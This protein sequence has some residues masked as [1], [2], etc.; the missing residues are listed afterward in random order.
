MNLAHGLYITNLGLGP[1]I[2]YIRTEGGWG[3]QQQCIQ[4]R[5]RGEGGSELDKSTHFVRMFTE[6]ATLS[7]SFKD[8]HQWC[9]ATLVKR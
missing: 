4:M 2:N 5:T 3:G 7:Q 8:R 9:G 6:N 1:S